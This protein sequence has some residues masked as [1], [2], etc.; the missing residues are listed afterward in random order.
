MGRGP[1]REEG[2]GCWGEGKGDRC[3]QGPDQTKSLVS[4]QIRKGEHSV[5]FRLNPGRGSEPSHQ[6]GAVCQETDVSLILSRQMNHRMYAERREGSV[7]RGRETQ[8]APR[9]VCIHVHVHASGCDCV[10]RAAVGGLEAAPFGGQREEPAGKGLVRA[11][12]KGMGW[13]GARGEAEGVGGPSGHGKWA[14]LRRKEGPCSCLQLGSC[15]VA[16]G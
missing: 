3:W 9:C 13:W 15:A 4:P 8:Q 1:S 11:A 5:Y 14:I 7:G 12:A 2:L 10:W 6:R 16:T